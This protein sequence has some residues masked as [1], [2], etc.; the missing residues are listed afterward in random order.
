MKRRGH[1]RK[2]RALLIFS[3]DGKF[4]KEYGS[5]NRAA[6]ELGVSPSTVYASLTAPPQNRKLLLKKY[7]VRYRDQMA[8]DTS[9]LAL[10]KN[11]PQGLNVP[12]KKLKSTNKKIVLHKKTLAPER[13]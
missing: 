6:F 13:L 1:S 11:M 7:I 12:S 4:L 2:P 9:S 5:Q 3:I 10:R 8:K